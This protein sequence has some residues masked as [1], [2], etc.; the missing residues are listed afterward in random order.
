MFQ[1]GLLFFVQ[2][3]MQHLLN[4]TATDNSRQ[5]QAEVIDSVTVG[6]QARYG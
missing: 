2:I 5:T 4:A 3:Q 6:H 1:S